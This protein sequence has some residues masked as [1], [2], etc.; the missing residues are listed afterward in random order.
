M[1]AAFAL[2]LHTHLPYV[3]RHGQWPHGSDWLCE[4]AAESYLPLL[5]VLERRVARDAPAAVTLSLTPV[6]CEQ[7]ADPE[8]PALFRRFLE[9][10]HEAARED[11]VRFLEDGETALAERAADWEAFYRG[12]LEDFLGAGGT[13][14]VARFRRLEERGV[15]EIVT[16][17]ATH[18]YLPLL[19]S[20]RAVSRQLRVATR[21]HRRHF[22]RAPRGMWLPECA[23]RPAGPWVS[24]FDPEART[25]FRPGL[26]S[27]LETE[28]L[29]FCFV[30]PHL[31]N[32]S[33]GMGTAREGGLPDDSRGPVAPR[34]H[35]EDLTALQ[36][37]SPPGSPPPRASSFG[38]APSSISR[39][40][41]SL[42]RAPS[43]LERASG[44]AADAARRADARDAASVLV[45]GRAT[46][47]TAGADA[48]HAHRV[49]G[50]ARLAC[51]ARDP[52]T[53]FQVWS[54]EHGYP[55]D[56][57]YLE[58]HK[59]RDPGGLR[60]WAVSDSRASLDRKR[61]YAPDAAARRVT[62]HARHFATLVQGALSDLSA[63]DP[64]SRDAGP[65]LLAALFDTELFGHW[66]FE[67]PAFLERALEEIERVGVEPVAI[68]AWLERHPPVDAVSLGEGS[69]GEGG[70]HRMWWNDG[71]REAWRAIHSAG[72][73][74]E[75]LAERAATVP[76]EPLLERLL[77]QTARE[78]LLLE[79]SDWTFLIT[80]GAA[81]DYAERRIHEHAADAARLSA[82][83]ERRIDGA[84]L[85]TSE[86]ES[87]E[88]LERRDAL[89]PDLQ[90]RE[91][92]G[93]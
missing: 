84:A 10:K 26:E 75:A 5:R 48:F 44:F 39:A 56:G 28:A 86:V 9:A 70:D 91:A 36:P 12:A 80:S 61:R 60:Y 79:A 51:V 57:A 88:A 77:V 18:A 73:R 92:A 38:R 63:A 45:A 66:W 33:P 19:G 81:R 82:L 4:A 71:T 50:A 65:P 22:G 74:F 53:A 46:S 15:I 58:F 6:L 32:A 47:A 8:F 24:P 49:A 1:A 13:N 17:A 35:P 29:S 52:A 83:V 54:G 90:W 85:S 30:D 72:Q 2:V 43:S 11:R 7:L 41:S 89:F 25:E 31:L 62:E 69:W 64:D 59:K 20:A 34:R 67:G 55:G 78:V 21:A 87:L 42:A 27:W 23:W 37:H 3:I 76:D 40:P 68:E 93:L 16:S 14:L